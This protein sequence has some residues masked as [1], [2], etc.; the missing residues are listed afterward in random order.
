MFRDLFGLSFVP[1]VTVGFD[2]KASKYGAPLYPDLRE[3][4]RI[5][6][7]VHADET[8]WRNDGS[9]HYVWFAGNEKLAFFHIAK[10]R[11][12]EVA[13]NILARSSKEFSSEIDTLPITVS[14]VTGS[15]A[16]LTSLPKPRR[17]ERSTASCR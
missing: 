8:S 1:A 11:S 9:G 12:T 4:I 3:K 5:S 7:V 10:S 17:S 14:A 6:E 15:R 16:W 2:R 13:N